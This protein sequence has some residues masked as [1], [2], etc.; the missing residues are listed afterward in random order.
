MCS[1]ISYARYTLLKKKAT[2]KQLIKINKTK[3]NKIKNKRTTQ[4]I[5]CKLNL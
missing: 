2:I 4:R 3:Y 5:N 1:D